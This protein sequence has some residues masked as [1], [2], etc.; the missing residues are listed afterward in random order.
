MNPEQGEGA[1]GTSGQVQECVV[2]VWVCVRCGAW[3]PQGWEK[4]QMAEHLPIP[5]DVC[6]F[7]G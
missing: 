3:L 5:K 7:P 4:E 1:K 6:H 2:P